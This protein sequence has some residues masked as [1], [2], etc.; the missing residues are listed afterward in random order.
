MAPSLVLGLVIRRAQ[1]LSARARGYRSLEDIPVEQQTLVISDAE[2]RLQANRWW[3]G[4]QT[5]S[6]LMVYPSIIGAALQRRDTLHPVFVAA[7]CFVTYS[8]VALLCV[9]LFGKRG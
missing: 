5:V 9:A 8:T 4:A 1:V 7:W 6:V 3:V 2:D